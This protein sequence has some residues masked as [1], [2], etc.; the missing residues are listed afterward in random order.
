MAQSLERNSG[1][2]SSSPDL[3]ELLEVQTILSAHKQTFNELTL[4]TSEQE[5]FEVMNPSLYSQI[6]ERL[7]VL[8]IVWRTRSLAIQRSIVRGNLPW[9]RTLTPSTG[10]YYT[11]RVS[12]NV[13]MLVNINERKSNIAAIKIRNIAGVVSCDLQ[14]RGCY[15]WYVKTGKD[16][17]AS[18]AEGYHLVARELHVSDTQITGPLPPNSAEDCN[19]LYITG[20]EKKVPLKVYKKWREIPSL[21]R[22]FVIE[23]RREP[24]SSMHPELTAI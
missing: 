13:R 23:A 5:D 8:N 7:S 4:L 18:T 19:R 10:T 11:L 9:D 21:G 17:F 12:D 15:D 20:E 3:C 6:R 24:D 14:L 22:S 16:F 2:L 1:G